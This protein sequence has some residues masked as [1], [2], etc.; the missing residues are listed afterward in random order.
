M[1]QL[2]FFVLVGASAA[3]THF[4]G[5][6]LAVQWLG[7]P[8]IWGNVFGFCCAFVVSFSGHLNLTFHQQQGKNIKTIAGHLWRWLFTS[9]LTFVLNQLLF[10]IGIRYWSEQY[11]LLIWFIVTLIVT[12]MSFLLGKLWAFRQIH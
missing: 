4:L 2:V 3:L 11:Y 5:L 10:V 12:V 7:I 6:L 9:L 8:A 1:K